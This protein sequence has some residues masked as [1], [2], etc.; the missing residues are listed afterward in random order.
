M[1]VRKSHHA[2]HPIHIFGAPWRRGAPAETGM[3]STLEFSCCFFACGRGAR[4]DV[5]LAPESDDDAV[6]EACAFHAE[7]ANCDGFELS[8]EE[9]LVRSEDR[10]S[11]AD[12]T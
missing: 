6:S 5:R 1:L 10:A 11:L 7:H 9:R 12:A 2:P 8:Q 3:I 4:I